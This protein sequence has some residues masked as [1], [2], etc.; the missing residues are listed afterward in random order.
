MR[1]KQEQHIHEA[2][3]DFI[4]RVNPRI[5]TGPCPRLCVFRDSSR[6]SSRCDGPQPS[7][8]TSS[9][10]VR[11][12]VFAPPREVSGVT[13][14]VRK[15]SETMTVPARLFTGEGHFVEET[16]M[17]GLRPTLAYFVP[18][19]PIFPSPVFLPRLVGARPYSNVRSGMFGGRREPNYLL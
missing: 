16:W 10:R 19:L 13:M 15:P 3:S 17:A 12:R 7:A 18:S 14:T 11:P 9:S 2:V 5:S 4:P 8:S 1:R 6:D